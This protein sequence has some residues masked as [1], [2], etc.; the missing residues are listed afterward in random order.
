MLD[1]APNPAD[2][3]ALDP[4]PSPTGAIAAGVSPAVAALGPGVAGLDLA[5]HLHP[6]A[7]MKD[8]A[9]GGV[10]VMTRG[11]GVY[12]TDS[13]GRRYLDA[14]AGLW[15]VNVGYGRREIADAVHAQMTEL[16]YYNTFFATTT[17]A[18]AQL[19]AKIC[20]HAGPSINRVFFTNSG[21]EAND[22]WLRLARVYWT[23][24]G[25]PDKSV[26][27]AR[28][29]AYHGSTV[30]GA[31]LG[32]MSHLHEQAGLAVSGI[33]HIGQPYWY[34]EGGDLSPAE[35]GLARA[36]ELE[37][38]IRTI[39]PGRVSAFV[40]EPIQ[41]VGGVIVPPETYWPEIQR[42]CRRYDVLLAVDEVITGFGRLGAWFG[43]QHYGLEPD[44]CAI[45]KGL[46]SGYLPIAGVMVSDR[47]ADVLAQAGPVHHG[48]T[49]SGHPAAAAAALANL[50]IL[51]DE[52]LVERVRDEIGPYLAG[53]WGG[54]SDHVMVGEAVSVGLLG[55]VQ[56][57]LDKATR[58]RFSRPG[59]IGQIVRNLCIAK[60]VIVRASGDRILVSP[61]FTIGR[62]EIDHIVAT[63]R[64][65]MDFVAAELSSD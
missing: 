50:R 22:T 21:S 48:F 45:A 29:N 3:S 49:S 1:V 18:T 51:E 5:H 61:P 25:K 26:V 44:F 54:L 37:E 8:L 46:S 41:G 28:H 53:A 20:Q 4:A 23:A 17:A 31:S 10:R 64:E 15:C 35:F 2:G 63:L 24:R 58:T 14:F 47:V 36:R 32:G 60:G 30:A 43:Y 59:D 52:R 57:V 9:G 11:E 34:G 19:A 42:I 7:D 39:G 40:A 65:V 12:V 13:E 16:A 33:H 38:A 62:D 55:A 27:I 6:F 56:L